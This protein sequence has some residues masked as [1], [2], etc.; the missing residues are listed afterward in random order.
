MRTFAWCFAAAGLIGCAGNSAN[1]RAFSPEWQNDGG[2]SITAVQARVGAARVDAGTAV[3]VAVTDDG[4]AGVLLDGSGKWKYAGKISAMPAVAGSIVV[5]STGGSVVGLDAKTGKALWQVDSEGRGLRG[6]GDD[7]SITVISL[8]SP[9]GGS[10][11]LLAVGRDGSVVRRL[12]P[13]PEIGTPAVQGGIAFVPWGNQYVS[14]IDLDGGNEVGRLL[15]REQVSHAVNLGGSL[16]FGELS[17]VRFDEHVGEAVEGKGTRVALP[18]RELP[19]KP[20]WFT[21][22]AQVD[23]ATATARERIRLFARPDG[24]NVSGGRF[25]ATYFR[26]VMGLSAQDGK[27]QWVGTTASDVIGGAGAEG[28]FAFCTEDGSVV[29]K[30]ETGGD[31]GSLSFEKNVRACVVH[32][33][34]FQVTRGKP[35]APLPQQIAKAIEVKESEMAIAQRFLLRELGAMQDAFVT[36][37]LIDLAENSRTSP[38]LLED[39]R[40]L[41]SSRRTGAEYMLESLSKHYDFLTDVL[42][43]PPVGP[44][45]DALAAMNESRAA[46]LLAKH[47][48]DPANTPDD[49]QRAARA[50]EKLSTG[51]ELEELKTFFALYRA[52][53]DQKELVSAVLSVARALVRVGGE[54]G[55]RLVRDAARDPLTHPDI[56]GGLT[57]LV[58]DEPAPAK[59]ASG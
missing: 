11:M 50:L 59:A 44:M 6:A 56:Q 1:G 36:K 34:N 16:Y 55:K 25:A 4:L 40:Q 43:P 14:A 12:T 10:S 53:A 15:L 9:T 35:P 22:G 39:A 48:N 54:D 30:D 17:L 45:A 13:E 47:L 46:P 57:G 38:M 3:A 28:G 19:G 20:L 31:A 7:G 26:I 42:R 18:T 2:K 52:T 27:L 29:L 24:P 33:G 21:D 41:L 23:P 51:S 32:A 49:I 8:G 37:V 58:G 5:A